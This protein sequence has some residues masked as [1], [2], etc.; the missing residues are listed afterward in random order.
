MI[1]AYSKHKITVKS[2]SLIERF[3]R[4]IAICSLFATFFMGSNFIST[5]YTLSGS[6]YCIGVLQRFLWCNEIKNE[7]NTYARGV[8]KNNTNFNDHL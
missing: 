6:I 5:G 8:R 7:F 2:K 1:K 4:I 3:I